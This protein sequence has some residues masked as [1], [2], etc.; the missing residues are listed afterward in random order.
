MLLK[1][2]DSLNWE[3]I[4]HPNICITVS[5]KKRDRDIKYI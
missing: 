1:Y 2:E 3:D 5:Q 4:K